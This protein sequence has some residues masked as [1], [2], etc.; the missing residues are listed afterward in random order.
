MPSISP[1]VLLTYSFAL[2][3]G[4]SKRLHKFFKS[5]NQIHACMPPRTSVVRSIG[6]FPILFLILNARRPPVRGHHKSSCFLH[7]S[8]RARSA[9]AITNV[10]RT[11][12][13][14]LRERGNFWEI[15]Y[16]D[17]VAQ[18]QI[19]QRRRVFLALD[20]RAHVCLLVFV[21]GTCTCAYTSTD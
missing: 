2:T 3:T 5:Y 8:G 10:T 13:F 1:T 19:Q 14:C 17:T 9:M 16:I 15:F 6:V 20:R 18:K 12:S 11:D 21:Q 4:S 7:G